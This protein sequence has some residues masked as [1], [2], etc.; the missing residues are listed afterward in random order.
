M[1]LNYTAAAKIEAAP[2]IN[3]TPLIDVLLVLLIIFMVISP[4]KP[5]RFEAKVPAEPPPQT[6]NV[7]PNPNALIVIV[8]P[9]ST[10][11]LNHE[12]VGSIA[13]PQALMEKLAFRFENNLKF[14]IYDE[15]LAKRE[16][17]SHEQKILKT[18]FIKAPKNFPYGEVAKVVD[19]VKAA[20]ANPVGLQIDALD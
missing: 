8:N 7:P 3:V 13:E 17:L 14:G 6:F 1:S 18:V 10:L 16:D 20:G 19:A 12:T 2:N 9:D 11:R 4:S 15:N 5:S